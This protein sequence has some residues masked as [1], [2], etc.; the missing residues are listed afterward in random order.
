V[1]F[2][3]VLSPAILAQC[4]VKGV[5]KGVEEKQKWFYKCL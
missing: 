3:K 1:L 5:E 4:C 2:V